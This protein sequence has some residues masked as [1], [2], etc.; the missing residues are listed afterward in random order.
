MMG[1]VSV[2]TNDPERATA[3]CDAG[4]AQLGGGDQGPPG[5]GMGNFYAA[6]LRD[7]DSKLNAF[8][9]VPD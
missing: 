8:C 6:C 4:L 5:Y 1:Y 3:F 2:V 7:L 9:I